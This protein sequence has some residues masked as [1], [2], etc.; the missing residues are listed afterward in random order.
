MGSFKLA[1]SLI[2]AEKTCPVSFSVHTF[3]NDNQKSWYLRARSGNERATWLNAMILERNSIKPINSASSSS[4]YK[5]SICLETARQPSVT[6]CGHLFCKNCIYRWVEEG[7]VSTTSHQRTCP[8]CNKGISKQQIVR[9]FG[10]DDSDS[11]NNNNSNSSELHCQAISNRSLNDNIEIRRTNAS[12]RMPPTNSNMD[13]LDARNRLP[14]NN[15]EIRGLAN[16]SP[17]HYSGIDGQV[18]RMSRKLFAGVIDVGEIGD[19]ASES[20]GEYRVYPTVSRFL[21][22]NSFCL[23]LPWTSYK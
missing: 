11:N 4:S 3:E 10:V 22:C 16:R 18:I 20:I 12:N 5:C 2:I 23:F 14:I 1:N 9:I 8:V 6:P 17:S 13:G 15:G 19:M 7:A 21:K